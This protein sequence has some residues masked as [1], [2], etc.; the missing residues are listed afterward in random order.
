MGPV[1]FTWFHFNNHFFF[2]F[3]PCAFYLT[4][5][6]V[7]GP[8]PVCPLFLQWKSFI[9]L[10][11]DICWKYLLIRQ[12]RPTWGFSKFQ[13]KTWFVKF[14]NIFTVYVIRTLSNITWIRDVLKFRCRRNPN[15]HP[16]QRSTI[17][18]FPIL[19]NLPPDFQTTG[20]PLAFTHQTNWDQ[21]QNKH[22]IPLIR[23]PSI[24]DHNMAPQGIPQIVT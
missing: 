10:F 19:E 1:W 2:C 14:A 20:R 15:G 12:V 17:L 11:V 8:T 18:R 23:L 3:S 9:W 24:F 22:M 5:I 4:R 13:T 6:S 16:W 7:K 21:W